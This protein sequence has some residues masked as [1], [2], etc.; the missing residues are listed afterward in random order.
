MKKFFMAFLVISLFIPFKN[1]FAAH[2]LITDDTGTQGRGN[3]QLEL[4]G[5][6]AW[7][8]ETEGGVTAKERGGEL[9]A[10][11]S[12]GVSD[13]V[14]LV[15]GVP[16]QWFE[17]KEDSLETEDESGIADLS[18]ELK[19]RFFEQEGL[20]LALKPGVTI[21]AGDEDRGLGTGRVTYSLFFITTK[22]AEPWAFHL[23]LG[24]VR[25]DNKLDERKDIWHASLAAEVEVA[26][27]LKLVGNIGA[28]SNPDGGSDTPPAFAIAGLI[29]EVSENLD[30]DIGIKCG[31]T[32][33]ETDTT[34][35]YGL[36]LRF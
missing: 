23:N 33:P 7:D 34:L 22:E 11:L 12:Y 19:W 5:E 10:A 31:L 4:N 17:V 25:N 27:N 14:D 29:Y 18:L 16:F 15:L 28:E 6:F 9:A 30:L 24:Y 3:F 1:S 21:P 8:K 36:A 26:E 2:P 32:K 13:S 35:L 20:S